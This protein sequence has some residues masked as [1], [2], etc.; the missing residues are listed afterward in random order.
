[1]LWESVVLVQGVFEDE[2]SEQSR[3]TNE[4]GGG[5]VFGAR[6]GK[7]D[8]FWVLG[9]ENLLPHL[10]HYSIFIMEARDNLFP[11]IGPAPIPFVERCFAG[12][13]GAPS[14]PAHPATP[15]RR[16]LL[17]DYTRQTA[18]VSR[19]LTRLVNQ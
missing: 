9:P 10:P 16:L 3:Q 19:L 6:R 7:A 1:M 17:H 2:R 8:R 13:E 11:S 5:E 14:P 18:S 4:S 15:G 12:Q